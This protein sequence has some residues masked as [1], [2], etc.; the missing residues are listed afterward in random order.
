LLAGAARR[1]YAAIGSVEPGGSHHAYSRFLDRA[2][3]AV[4]I[5]IADA[6][7]TYNVEPSCHCG[8][9]VI[10]DPRVSQEGRF[11]QCL[12]DEASAQTTLKAQWTQYPA[13][14]RVYCADTAR[15]GTPSYVELLTCLEMEEDGRSLPK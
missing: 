5:T 2:A 7:P 13:G 11:T 6:S 15:L 4:A 3:C 9:D 1:R 12:R 8:M 10:A 14:D